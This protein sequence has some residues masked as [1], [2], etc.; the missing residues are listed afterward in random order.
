MAMDGQ[1]PSWQR[2]GKG[3]M[4]TVAALQPVGVSAPSAPQ[5]HGD[6]DIPIP[7][8]QPAEDRMIVHYHQRAKAGPVVDRGT[9]IAK[10]VTG[11][12]PATY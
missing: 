10:P 12:E 8:L 9:M 7:W 2:E 3:V 4:A 5:G 11:F 1:E 6:Q